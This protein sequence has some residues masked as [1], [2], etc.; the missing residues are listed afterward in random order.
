VF[1]FVFTI[2]VLSWMERRLFRMAGRLR[3]IVGPDGWDRCWAEWH[4]RGLGSVLIFIPPIFPVLHRLSIWKI[5]ILGPRRLRHGPLLHKIGLLGRS[6]IP[7]NWASLY[8]PAIWHAVHRKSLCQNDH[9]DHQHGH[10][11]RGAAAIFVLLVGEFF[12]AHQGR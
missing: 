9:H 2:S 10:A 6:F 11:L 1:Q 7:M 12:R 5:R 8:L 3:D 4:H